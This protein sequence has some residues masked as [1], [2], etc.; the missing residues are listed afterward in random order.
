MFAEE[1]NFNHSTT[2]Y[3]LSFKI[4]F[5]KTNSFHS[6]LSN[7]CTFIKQSEDLKRAFDYDQ[8]WFLIT[9]HLYSL[10]HSSFVPLD[11]KFP[12][13]FFFLI[14]FLRRRTPA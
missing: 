9:N 12:Q 3:K 4:K 1:N 7:T 6:L 10:S 13:I 5:K 11:L 2:L 14:S 8:V